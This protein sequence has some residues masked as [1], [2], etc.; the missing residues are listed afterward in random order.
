MPAVKRHQRHDDTKADQV[1]EDRQEDDQNRRLPH[2]GLG[3]PR[4]KTQNR[5]SK[6]IGRVYFQRIPLAIAHILP[7]ELVK[8]ED[9]KRSELLGDTTR[10]GSDKLSISRRK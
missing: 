10:L 8:A 5:F 6:H 9:T 2:F 3:Y 4:P 7:R 1:N